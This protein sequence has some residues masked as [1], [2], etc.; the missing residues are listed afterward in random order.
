M[1][2]W[3]DYKG[4]NFDSQGNQHPTPFLAASWDQIYRQDRA[5]QQAQ[6]ERMTSGFSKPLADV[7]QPIRYQP[8]AEEE[9]DDSWGSALFWSAL[10]FILYCIF[11]GG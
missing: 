8:E 7:P 10:G 2:M 6:Y 3:T 5:A 4:R 1:T 9:E 11:I